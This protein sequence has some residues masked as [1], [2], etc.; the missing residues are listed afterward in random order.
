VVRFT[1][2]AELPAEAAGDLR[3]LQA[4]GIGAA[5]IVPLELSDRVAGAL[6]IATSREYVNWPDALL[7]RVQL[8][9]QAFATVI[10]RQQ[11]EQRELEAQAQAA[12]SARVATLGVFAAS[13]VHELTQPLAA[14]LANAETARNLLAL[15]APRLGELRETIDDIVTDSR[16]AGE[17]IQ[18]LRRF[19]RHGEAERSE[20]D[21][22]A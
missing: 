6:S 14:S 1:C 5:V 21:V 16:R 15:P 20:I 8:L 11:S 13:L 3:G 7:P 10:A 9:G 22:Q 12:H 2:H 17:L 19:L 18:K 4:L